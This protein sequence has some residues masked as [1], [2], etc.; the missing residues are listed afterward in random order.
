MW[1]M[2]SNLALADSLGIIDMGVRS[3]QF[4]SAFKVTSD[5]EAD[6]PVLINFPALMQQCKQYAL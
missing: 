3:R 4:Q 6:S 1:S 2:R 5:Y